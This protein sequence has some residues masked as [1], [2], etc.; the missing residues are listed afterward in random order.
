MEQGL[1]PLSPCLHREACPFPGGFSPKK[2]K[3]RWCHFAFDTE[4]APAELLRLSGVAGIPKERA[5]LSFI[6]AVKE[7]PG[8]PK[9]AFGVAGDDTTT[10][11]VLSDSFAVG[12]EGRYG[13]Y[14][15]SPKGLVLAAGSG[16]TIGQALPGSALRLTLGRDR[17]PKS[18]ALVSEVPARS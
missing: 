12:K 3:A 1:F 8:A 4:D 10:A 16:K 6:F 5:V 7:L 15:C 13:R 11:L 17:D 14:C 9:A 18:G 2:G